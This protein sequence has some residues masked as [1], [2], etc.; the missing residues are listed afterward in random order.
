MAKTTRKRRTRRQRW[1][2]ARAYAGARERREAARAQAQA[3][4][5]E[6][7]EGLDAEG[8]SWRGRIRANLLPAFSVLMLLGG[9]LGIPFLILDTTVPELQTALGM[10]GAPGTATVLS[11]ETYQRNRRDTRRDCE[12]WFVFEDPARAPI[13]IQTVADVK[14]GETFPAAIG[15]RGDHVIPTG[16]RG[17][18]R[19]IPLMSLVLLTPAIVLVSFG[20]IAQSRAMKIAAGV[21]VVIMAAA[22]TGGFTLGQ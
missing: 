10:K 2:A 4:K 8:S 17:V 22:I 9:L 1:E 6:Q 19:A 5:Q 20:L 15:P 13:V 12:A 14:V 7:E 18:W 3:Q 16:T 11:C 21:L